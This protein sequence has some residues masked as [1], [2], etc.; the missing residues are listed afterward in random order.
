VGDVVLAALAPMMSAP[1][2]VTATVVKTR[3]A[4]CAVHT[5]PVR[6]EISH[7]VFN[8]FHDGIKIYLKLSITRV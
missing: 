6:M 4:F 5:A 2:M 8:P 3:A 7:V 1:M